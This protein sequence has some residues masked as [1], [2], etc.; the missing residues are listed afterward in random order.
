[1]ATQSTKSE[2]EQG[3][4]DDVVDDLIGSFAHDLVKVNQGSSITGEDEEDNEQDDDQQEVLIAG[5]VSKIHSV[6]LGFNLSIS[7]HFMPSK[8]LCNPLPFLIILIVQ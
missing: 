2:A 5:G 6:E 1:M 8:V 7:N 4:V 3:E